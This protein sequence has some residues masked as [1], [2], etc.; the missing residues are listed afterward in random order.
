MVV[1]C[2]KQQGCIHINSVQRLKVEQE[3][4]LIVKYSA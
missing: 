4:K 1:S 2:K 3:T